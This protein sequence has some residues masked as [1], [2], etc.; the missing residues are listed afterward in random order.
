MAVKYIF[1]P[2]TKSLGEFN[3]RRALP[4]QQQMLIGPWIF[5]DHMGPATFPANKGVDVR[6]HPHINLATVTY[7]F[8]GQILHRDSL[9]SLQQINP[10]DINLMVAGSGITHSERETPE[11]RQVEHELHGLQLWHALPEA[12]EE[13][14]PAFYH[15]P[16]KEIP[17]TNIDGTEVRVMMGSAY[18]VTS[19]V[20]TFCET[21]YLET[22]LKSGDELSTPQTE[23]L[24]IY[25]VSGQLEIDGEIIEAYHFVILQDNSTVSIKAT[26]TSQIAMVG[27]TALGKRYIEWN[28]VSSRAERI[29]QAKQ[30][31][32]NGKFPKVI[33]DDQEYIPLPSDTVIHPVDI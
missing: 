10:G 30:D 7:L 25:V 19:P 22:L 13:I 20:K 33:G 17:T 21:L 12:D 6:P 4:Y 28:F 11:V 5:F 1:Q 31:W 27:G 3:V 24:G 9:G 23:Q 14:A 18:G 2:N 29:T 15:Y 26:K 16:A 8:A 32:L